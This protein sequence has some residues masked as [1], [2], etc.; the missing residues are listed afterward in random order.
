MKDRKLAAR[1]AR[2][3]LSA[4]SDPAHAES[5]DRFLIN[6]AEAMESSPPFRAV[7]L[8]PAVSRADRIKVLESLAAR[9]GQGTQVRNFLRT[10]VENQRAGSI[11]S[12]AAVFHEVREEAAGI[13]PAE[14]T[15][16]FPLPSDLQERAR[17]AIQKMTGG[18][19]RLDC[20]VDEDLVGGAV[21]RIGGTVFDGSL[22]TQL[23]QLH[24]RMVQE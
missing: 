16:A 23:G 5:A 21:T 17:Q 12:I 18:T 6:L 8:D 22:K 9:A 15:T 11:P 14:I 2:A 4:L 13:I 24:K 20:K 3:L 1:Y 19:V 10:L 7:M